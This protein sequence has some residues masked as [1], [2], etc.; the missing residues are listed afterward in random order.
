LRG[1]ALFRN[2]PIIA[3]QNII[4]DMQWW[5][6]ALGDEEMKKEIIS[7]Y[8]S[9]ID[10]CEASMKEHAGDESELKILEDLKEYWEKRYLEIEN[11]F[12]VVV[13]AIR[14]SD[15]MVLQLEDMTLDLIYF[16]LGHSKSDIL[17][18][19]PEEKVL[20]SGAAIITGL[21][22]THHTGDRQRDV[23]LWIYVL[24][25]LTDNINT[26]ETI[27]PGHGG[28]RDKESLRLHCEYFTAMYEK[29]E[30]LVTEGA[31]LEDARSQ[32]TLDKGF[33]EFTTLQDLPEDEKARHLE[34]V[35]V[36]WNYIQSE[37]DNSIGGSFDLTRN[38]S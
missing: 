36:L 32:L 25:K 1:N 9:T 15:E 5:F 13:P 3:H 16:G 31:S 29:V 37:A 12:E 4:D 21:P 26:V 24:K 17:I 10:E 28:L 19:I 20:I 2:I 38:I 30:K 7:Y 8:R 33:P 27:I 23:V 35:K 11:G 14:F 6:D 18:H 22:S 34:N